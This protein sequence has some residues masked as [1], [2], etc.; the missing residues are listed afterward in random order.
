MKDEPGDKALRI[1]PKLGLLAL[2]LLL[3]G[4]VLVMQP[5]VSSLM[6][7]GVLCFTLWPATQR[8]RGWLETGA[9]WR[10]S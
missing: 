6:W 3:I 4:C 7:A 1:E 2:V 5:F 8:L 9:R 10:R